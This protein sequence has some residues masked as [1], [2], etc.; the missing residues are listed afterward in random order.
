[1]CWLE[2]NTK[3]TRVAWAVVTVC[4]MCAV[5]CAGESR[6]V[7]VKV[8]GQ[9]L[10]GDNPVADARVT[11]HPTGE[12][13]AVSWLPVGTTDADGWYELTTFTE[14]DGAPAGDYRVTV[15]RFKAVKAG[16]E[17]VSRNTLPAHFAQADASGL[18]VSVKKGTPELEPLQVRTK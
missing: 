16:D 1:M 13:K 10:V 14:K 4:A 2:W 9:V 11:F 18:T 6:P 17:Y 3:T 5:G 7:P 12:G 15:S 8:R